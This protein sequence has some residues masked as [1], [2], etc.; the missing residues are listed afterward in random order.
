[1]RIP[2][3]TQQDE[4][5]EVVPKH[6]GSS[7]ELNQATT[8]HSNKRQDCRTGNNKSS[9]SDNVENQL[10]LARERSAAPRAGLTWNEMEQQRTLDRERKAASRAAMTPEEAE[11]QRVLARERSAARRASL[12]SN[13]MEQQRTLNRERKAASRAAMTPEEAERQRVLVRER[14]AVNRAAMTPEEAERQR[15]LARERNAASRISLT[16]NEMEQQRTITRE[17]KTAS[18]AAMT[19]EQAERQRVLARERSM[20]RRAVASPNESEL[21]RVLARERSSARRATVASQSVEQSET[22]AHKKN[23]LQTNANS[24]R[25]VKNI[26]AD[27]VQVKWPKATDMTCKTTCLKNFI[28]C[29]SMKSLKEGVCSICNIRCYKRDLRCVPYNKIPSIELLKVHSDL[30][31]IIPG[32][33]QAES[34]N[35]DNRSKMNNNFQFATDESGKNKATCSFLLNLQY[36]LFDYRLVYGIFY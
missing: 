24:K 6:L 29:M 18:R 28:Q 19:P 21:Q 3:F 16:S 17:R 26:K 33:Q 30:Y 27:N 7:I 1:M 5:T 36:I 14:S 12:T 31:S 32:L 35:L 20:A 4:R 22:L 10:L 23:R 13:E 25:S 15:V 2:Q 8:T 34:W 9:V 11:R